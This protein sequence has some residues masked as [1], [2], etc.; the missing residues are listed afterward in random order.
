MSALALAVNTWLPRPRFMDMSPDTPTAART[1]ST[2]S[3]PLDA[4]SKRTREDEDALDAILAEPPSKRLEMTQ[5]HTPG[6]SPDLYEQMPPATRFA[7]VAF[8]TPISGHPISCPL[9]MELRLR[10]AAAHTTGQR[11][12]APALAPRTPQPAR[13]CPSRARARSARR[14]ATRCGPGMEPCD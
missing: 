2:G 4:H 9:A 14:Q 1:S 10:F 8:G 6:C 12:C 7:S 11:S 5:C 3:T 13:T